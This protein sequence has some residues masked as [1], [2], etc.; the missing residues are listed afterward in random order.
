[1]RLIGTLVVFVIGSHAPSAGLVV[2]LGTT[3]GQ[4]EIALA[5]SGDTLVHGLTLSDASLQKTRQA[6]TQANLYGLASV[7]KVSSF[8]RLPSVSNL[9]NVLIVDLDQLGKWAADQKELLRPLIP[10]GELRFKKNGTWQKKIKPTPG[11]MDEWTHWDHDASGNPAS[12]D[13]YVRPPTSLQWY[14]G[15]STTDNGADKVG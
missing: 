9:V 15:P 5:K 3:D 12:T 6:I 10:G 11:G 13:I 14:A 8:A 1:M 2:H 7:E 4:L